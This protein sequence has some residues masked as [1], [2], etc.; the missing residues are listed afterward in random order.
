MAKKSPRWEKTSPISEASHMEHQLLH[1]QPY[2]RPIKATSSPFPLHMIEKSIVET[3]QCE[4]NKY[5]FDTQ[6]A[7]FG[8]QESHSNFK[9]EKFIRL[10]SIQKDATR[11]SIPDWWSSNQSMDI[12]RQIYEKPW[13][14]LPVSW[15]LTTN[16]ESFHSFNLTV[17]SRYASITEIH[18][19]QDSIWALES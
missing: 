18:H 15:Q 13:V 6:T 5:S 2:I 12:W 9:S 7:T 16:H 11:R 1:L 17:S 14:Q 3:R 19:G 8:F 4:L 10:P